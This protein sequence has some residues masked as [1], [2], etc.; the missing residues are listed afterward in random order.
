ML[1]KI[2][3]VFLE[4]NEKRNIFGVYIHFLPLI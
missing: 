2:F 1:V 4:G 3:N